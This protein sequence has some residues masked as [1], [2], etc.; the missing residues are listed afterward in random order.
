LRVLSPQMEPVPDAKIVIQQGEAVQLTVPEEVDA[1]GE[2]MLASLSGERFDF[3]VVAKGFSRKCVSLSPIPEGRF[4]VVLE[5]PQ[6]VEV[7]LVDFDGTPYTK[8]VQFI[9][10]ATNPGQAVKVPMGPG[11]FRLDELPAGDVMLTIQGEFGSLARMHYAND[12][13][14]RVVIGEPGSIEV[15]L[16]CRQNEYPNWMLEAAAPGSTRGSARA[17]LGYPDQGVSIASFKSLPMGEYEIWFVHAEN[18]F[19]DSFVRV[20]TPV[21]VV[22]DANHPSVK[23]EM[24]LP[25]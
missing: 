21:R 14:L 5:P 16:D 1:N 17:Y 6:S 23:L 9:S 12:P 4:D 13:R 10:D 11:L 8:A 2:L 24:K 19:V 22:I 20:G 7:E 3:V 18:P 25:R 15:T